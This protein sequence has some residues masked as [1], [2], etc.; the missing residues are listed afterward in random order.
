MRYV[1]LI[2]IALIG[3]SSALHAQ[4]TVQQPVVGTTGVATSVSVPDRGST[5]LGG[6]SSAQSFR[7][8]YGPLRTGTGRGYGL[9]GG[10]MSAHVYIIDLHAMDE[11]I[12][13]SVPDSLPPVSIRSRS[14]STERTEAPR[15]VSPVEKAANFERL[16]IHAEAAGKTG[17]A[18]LHWQMAAKYG[19]TLAAQKLGRPAVDNSRSTAQK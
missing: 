8:S 3:S 4:L 18:R 6:V 5:F 9:S 19:S 15:E 14:V 7:N 16:A 13:N 12:L 1:S 17:V 11:A 2:A 10:S